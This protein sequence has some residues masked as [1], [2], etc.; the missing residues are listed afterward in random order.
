MHLSQS[1]PMKANPLSSVNQHSKQ[2]VLQS[3]YDTRTSLKVQM[4]SQNL[5]VLSCKIH[6]IKQQRSTT[7]TRDYMIAVRIRLTQY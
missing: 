1:T 4:V 2:I 6:S 3:D 5:P 7:V